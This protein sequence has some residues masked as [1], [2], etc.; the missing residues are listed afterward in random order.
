MDCLKKEID[1]VKRVTLILGVVA[2]MVA[3]LVALAGPAMAK[4]NGGHNNGGGKDN[5]GHN[6]GGGKDNGGINRLDNRLDRVDNRVNLDDGNFLVTDVDRSPVFTTN[7]GLADDLCSPLSSEAINDTIP[8]CIFGDRNNDLNTDFVSDIDFDNVDFDRGTDFDN[9]DFMDVD[10]D[11][12]FAN[13]N[14]HNGNTNGN[15]HIGNSNGNAH[16]NG[17]SQHNGGGGQKGKGK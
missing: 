8:D 11:L 5:G 14:N 7:V 6:N 10:R 3:M 15:D 4:D 12:G 17:N 9:V 1:T 2:V 13:G 16:H